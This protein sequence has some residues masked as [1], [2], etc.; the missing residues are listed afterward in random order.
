[1]H[2]TFDQDILTN[3]EK[4]VNFIQQA[5]LGQL[6]LYWETEKVPKQKYSQKVVGEDFEKRIQDSKKDVLL[7]VTHPTKD[8][9]RKILAAYEELSRVEQFK[10]ENKDIL[11]ARYMGVNESQSFKAPAKLPALLYF[12]RQLSPSGEVTGEEKEIITYENIN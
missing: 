4:L 5:V 6:P 7:L 10:E 3:P 11:F 1:M 8:K 2:H 12:K 9:N